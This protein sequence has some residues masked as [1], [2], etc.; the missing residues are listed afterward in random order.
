MAIEINF[1]NKNKH[2]ILIILG[3]IKNGLNS[4]CLGFWHL[5]QRTWKYL[6]GVFVAIVI[7]ILSILGY[8]YYTKEYYPEKVLKEAVEMVTSDFRKEKDPQ[9]KMKMVKRIFDED[10]EWEVKDVNDRDLYNRLESF[11]DEIFIYV[12]KKASSGDAYSQHTLGNIYYF[13]KNDY[14]KAAYWWNEAANHG[15]I[16]AYNNMGLCYSHFY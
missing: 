16:R 3:R 8:T 4:L 2:W 9:K 5:L 1:N 7:V 10:T 15:Y 14:D 11:R 12:E 6:L 13:N